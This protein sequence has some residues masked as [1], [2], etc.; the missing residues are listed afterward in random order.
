[1]IVHNYYCARLK[2]ETTTKT[3]TTS[4]ST[5]KLQNTNHFLVNPQTTK[6][7]PLPCQP[8]KY[9][10]QKSI[11]QKKSRVLNA[12]FNNI[13]VISWWSVLL[14]EETRENHRPATSHCQ[15]LSHNVVSSTPQLSVIRTH[16]VSGD[17]S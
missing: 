8:S 9:K 2:I 7:K 15:T 6:H 16:N 4:L 5:L 11:R 13:S 1:M 14:V 17:R 3:H 10:T 12:T